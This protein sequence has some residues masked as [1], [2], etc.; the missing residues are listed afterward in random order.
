[1]YGGASGQG[2]LGVVVFLVICGLVIGLALSKSDLANPITSLAE[3][4]RYRTETRQLA[5]KD[6]V[7]ATEYQKLSEA[8][9][10]AEIRRLNEELVQQERVHQAEIQ[11]FNAERQQQAQLH[12]E[13]MRQ[14]QAW[15]ALKMRLVEISVIVLAA[16]L[17]LSFVVVSV[18]VSKR[19]GHHPPCPPQWTQASLTLQSP[20]S[21]SRQSHAYGRGVGALVGRPQPGAV[22]RSH[23]VDEP[24]DVYEPEK[25]VAIG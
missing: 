16:S 1:M 9:T 6:A 21:G 14:A 11:R 18:G 8:Q 5:E 4:D 12:Q 7:D 13:E 15:A 2:W 23:N 22:D 17:G 19:L 3:S 24:E 10:Q 20:R 25:E